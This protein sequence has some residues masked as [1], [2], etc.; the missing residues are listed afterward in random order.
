[1][2]TTIKKPINRNIIKMAILLLGLTDCG[3]GAT[4]AALA[5][6]SAAFPTVSMGIIQMVASVPALFFA[7]GPTLCYAPMARALKKRTILWIGF[8][9]FVIGGLSPAWM[10]SSIEMILVFRACLGLGLGILTPLGVDLICDIFEGDEKRTMLGLNGAMLGISGLLFQTLGGFLSQIR[11]DY[12]FFAYLPGIAFLIFA[13][14]FLPEP[15]KRTVKVEENV[16]KVKAKLPVSAI[17]YIIMVFFNG[18][19]F[20]VAIT[21]SAFV[22][23][24]DNIAQPYQIGLMFNALTVSAIIVGLIFGKLFKKLRYWIFTFSVLAGGI[25]LFLCGATNSIVVF[26]I[27]LFLVGF[28]L[29]GVIVSAESKISDVVSP[30]MQALGISLIVTAMNMGEFFQPVIFNLFSEPGRQPFIIGAVAFVILAVISI[31]VEK[32]TKD[33]TKIPEIGT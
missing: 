23:V 10:N 18:M 9:L 5:S 13:L 20:Y 7:I 15:K 27:G 22:L 6:I 31:F 30:V 19:F 12:T 8:V 33:K 16:P 24:G 4:T 14:V 3:V 26:S 2:E 32:A 25:G 28:T 11:W 29:S 17:L 1:M 21:N